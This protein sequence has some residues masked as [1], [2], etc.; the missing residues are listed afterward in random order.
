MVVLTKAGPME[1]VGS[2][3]P[4]GKGA[5][6]RRLLKPN[7]TWCISKTVHCFHCFCSPEMLRR[8]TPEQLQGTG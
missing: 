6:F 5:F 1:S 4:R 8:W 7:P 3:V 2:Q